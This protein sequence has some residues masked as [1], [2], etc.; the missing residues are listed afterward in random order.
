MVIN[1]DNLDIQGFLIEDTFNPVKT[2]TAAPMIA[3]P[4]VGKFNWPVMKEKVFTADKPKLAF[5]SKNTPLFQEPS[6][7]RF[8]IDQS[9]LRAA[10]E[11]IHDEIRKLFKKKDLH[12][13]D[14]NYLKKLD[15]A[16]NFADN[17]LALSPTKQYQFVIDLGDYD[18]KDRMDVLTK[19]RIALELQDLIYSG[20]ATEP[21]KLALT[22]QKRFERSKAYSE[23]Y[24][25]ELFDE[26]V[27]LLRT[28]WFFR[29][30]E[31]TELGA[32]EIEFMAR[33]A[34][35]R[36]LPN[37][38]Q[39]VEMEDAVQDAINANGIKR[40]KDQVFIEPFLAKKRKTKGRRIPPAPIS[41]NVKK[42]KGPRV[43]KTRRAEPMQI[44]IVREQRE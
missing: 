12:V 42:V 34:R 16:F 2:V 17:Y 9:H 31:F 27:K 15:A 1:V 5:I 30:I 10:T 19:L 7:E 22:F 44:P 25:N 32:E 36:I 35:K 38:V 4:V 18:V 29:N 6:L 23:N 40:K 28:S 14:P 43:R 21:Q 33:T 39:D 8:K 11:Q 41:T 13:P 24:S 3:D 20:G 26:I 37:F